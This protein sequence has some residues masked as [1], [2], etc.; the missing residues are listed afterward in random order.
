MRTKM[1]KFRVALIISLTNLL[2][3]S[4]IW[5]Q[6]P[7]KMSYQAVIR[8]SSNQLVTNQSIGMQVSI[9]K[10]SANGT[11]VYIE[12]QTPV[13]NANGLVSIEIGTG[14]TSND[15]SVI[16]W[17]NGP[18]FIKTETD[19]ASGTNYTITGTSQLL[20]VPYALHAKTAETLTGEITETDPVYS[21][22][23]ASGITATDTTNWNNKLD[24]ET[25]PVFTAWDKDYNDLTNKPSNATTSTD[26]FMSA[27]DKTKLSGLANVN[28]TGGWGISVMGIYPNISISNAQSFYLGQEYLDGI[29][30]YLYTDSYGNQHGLVV[31]KTETTAQWQSTTSATNANRTEDGPYNTGL[32]VNSPAKTW[33]EG[34]G[35]GW[36]LPSVDE[37]SLLWQNR[38]HVDKT[39]RAIG[40]T[41]L[42]TADNYWSSTEYQTLYAWGVSFIYGYTERSYSKTLSYRVRGVRSF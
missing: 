25:D 21:T 42:S 24:S 2:I 11:A 32:M 26:G 35:T 34:L 1:D 8:N 20:S 28:I 5:A 30:F 14:T 36:Y 29:I 7:E 23:L 9:V 37:L 39:A 18:Y 4:S 19:P 40:S 31:S 6:S 27:S 15:F 38:Y 3:S 22:S 41:L 13:T 10:D 16:N 33:V 17:S 12:T